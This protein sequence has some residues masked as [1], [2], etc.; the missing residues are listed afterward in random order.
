MSPSRVPAIG[1][2]RAGAVVFATVVTA[3]GLG[4]GSDPGQLTSALATGDC[5]WQEQQELARELASAN[6]NMDC[7]LVVPDAPLTAAGLATPW[8]LQATDSTK[9]PCIEANPNQGAFVEATIDDPTAHTLLLYH[10]LVIDDGRRALVTPVPPTLPAGAIVGIRIGSNATFN[11]L[12]G[13]NANTLANANCID[14]LGKDPFGQVSACNAPAFFAATGGR[15]HGRKARAPPLGKATDGLTC[16]TTRDFFIVDQD[17]SDNVLTTYLADECGDTAQNTTANAARF[18]NATTLANGSDNRLLSKVDEAIGCTGWAVRDLTG[19]P[20]DTS[21]ALNE[22][23][24]TLQ[25]APIALVPVGDPMVLLGGEVDNATGTPSTAKMDLYR[26]IVGQPANTL[27]DTT[28]YCTELIAVGVPRLAKNKA[29]LERQP[30]LVP[31][32]G[33]NLFTFLAA[34]LMATLAPPDGAGAGL[35]PKGCTQLL[36][37][38][39]PITVTTNGQGVAIAATINTNEQP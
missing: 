25:Q 21:Q 14:G 6:P 7:T 34:R 39:N 9:G 10:P 1:L 4:G 8:R 3:C 35:G 13:A 37:L 15:P 26:S 2:R 33:N 17:Q 30:S 23:Q 11:R 27:D 38:K 18:Q 32:V 22:L 19:G 29:V 28:R 5:S 16:P 36:G 12:V 31:A 20:A 24:A